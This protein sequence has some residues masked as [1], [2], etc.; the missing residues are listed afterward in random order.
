MNDL[1]SVL[2]YIQTFNSLKKV[3]GSSGAF[4]G[5]LTGRGGLAGGTGCMQGRG[6]HGIVLTNQIHNVHS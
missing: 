3:T 4:I 5:R 1:R 6:A 2:L